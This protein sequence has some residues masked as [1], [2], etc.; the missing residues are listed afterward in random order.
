MW[1][2]LYNYNYNYN[3]NLRHNLSETIYFKKNHRIFGIA[4]VVDFTRQPG[5]SSE[6]SQDHLSV[7]CTFGSLRATLLE[8]KFR[9]ARIF[10]DKFYISAPSRASVWRKFIAPEGTVAGNNR[11]DLWNFRLIPRFVRNLASLSSID[12]FILVVEYLHFVN[13]RLLI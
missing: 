5:L 2:I 13:I 9:R 11:R 7:T 10:L 8:E 1:S 6:V 12:D 4:N 3:L